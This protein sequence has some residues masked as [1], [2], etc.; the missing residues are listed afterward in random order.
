M[1]AAITGFGGAFDALEIAI[2]NTP[3]EDVKKKFK[4]YESKGYTTLA[5]FFGT[6]TR[7]SPIK[8]EEYLQRLYSKPWTKMIAEKLMKFRSV[9]NDAKD[10]MADNI[11]NS[12]N[13]PEFLKFCEFV[14]ASTNLIQVN[15]MYD[16]DK[17]TGVCSINNFVAT[18]PNELFDRVYFEYQR[19]PAHS[20]RFKIEVGGKVFDQELI[21]D[22]VNFSKAPGRAKS[23]Q[24]KTSERFASAEKFKGLQIEG[25]GE[26]PR[27]QLITKGSKAGEFENRA[28]GNDVT[29][30]TAIK[31]MY[32]VY[33]SLM[34]KFPSPVVRKLQ[35]KK[36]LEPMLEAIKKTQ[37]RYGHD[38]TVQGGIPYTSDDLIKRVQ[39]MINGK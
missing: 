24:K 17:Q 4:Y 15:T 28:T 16:E 31:D 2:A 27:W 6:L 18:W 11:I 26:I 1:P 36:L 25:S 29:W 21:D 20:L 13:D 8:S 39:N 12:L 37:K 30:N 14:L 23:T 22:S 32:K 3:N 19:V 33:E 34:A 10:K 7:N 5:S 35:A 38:A 9:D